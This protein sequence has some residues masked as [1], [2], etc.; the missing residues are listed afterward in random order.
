MC[1]VKPEECWF[2]TRTKIH[3][4]KYE[5]TSG[6]IRL[7][8]NLCDSLPLLLHYVIFPGEGKKS[9]L[10]PEIHGARVESIRLPYVVCHTKLNGIL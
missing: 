3:F 5:E 4:E 10:S 8:R 9:L 2:L 1:S 7:E 6:R